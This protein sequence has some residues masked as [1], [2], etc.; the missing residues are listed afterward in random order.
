MRTKIILS[1]IAALLMQFVNVRADGYSDGIMKLINSDAMGSFNA[2]MFEQ[3]SQIP[4]V[5]AGYIQGQFKTDA[6]EWLAGHYRK[7]M[8]E[9]EFGDMISFFMQPEVLAIQK[10][11]LSAAASSQGQEAMQSLMPQMQA[12]MTG[13]TPEDLKEPDCDPQ[14]KKE[15]LRWLEI[16]NS[17]ESM[18]ASL[19]CAKGLVADMAPEGISADQMEMMAKMMDGMF[20]FMEKNMNT[21]VLTALVG[22]VN[23]KDMQT[24]NAVEKKPFFASY[25][26]ANVSLAGDM[27]TFMKKVLDGMKK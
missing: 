11:V 1:F 9:K 6:A 7:N 25:K 18:K 16:N 5:N 3:M 27:S 15:I 17:A 2:K 8:S 14:L 10:K 23:I 19:N 20:S 26:K 21:L 12:L 24:L 4:S 22:K 13:G